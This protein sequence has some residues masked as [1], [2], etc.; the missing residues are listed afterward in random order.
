MP[1]LPPIRVIAIDVLGTLVDEP[2]ARRETIREMLPGVGA[3]VVES[4]RVRWESLI[5]AEQ[6]LIAR[7]ERPYADAD[8]LDAETLV[9]LGR[10]AGVDPAVT[11]T[12]AA[13]LGERLTPWSDAVAGVEG[14]ARRHPIFGLSNATAPTLD[15]L[16]R[17]TG[18]AWTRALSAAQVRAYKPSP[19]VYRLAAD[20]AGVPPEQVLMVAAHAWDLRAAQAI[21]MRTAYVAR[22]VGDPPRPDDRFDGEFGTLA[23]LAAA[24]DG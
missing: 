4:H 23:E 24:L 10:S 1:T 3:E 6:S 15:A 17:R 18:L 14:L 16:A 22:P 11:V 12:V 8:V 9:E 7:G 2:A 19:E 5:A 13:S 21:G 20:T